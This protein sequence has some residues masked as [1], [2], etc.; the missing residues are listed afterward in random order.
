[1][2]IVITKKLL[3][4]VALLWAALCPPG[5]V[6]ADSKRVLVYYMPWFA[7]KPYSANWG[8]H[9][10][11][12]HFNPEILSVTGQR[13]IASW[14]YPLIGP[15]DSA[16]PAVLEYHVLLMKL[17]GIDGVV[18]DWYGSVNY[19]DYG[20]N[21]QA[22][23]K[24][25]QFARKAGLTCCICYEDQTIQHMIDGGYLAPGEAIRH[26]QQEVG[27]LQTNFFGDASYL[28]L[29]GRP[30]LLNFGPQH[31]L[32]SS[33]WEEIFSVLA[34]TNRP[35]FFT[36]DNR[37]E[38]AMGAFSWPPMWLSQAPGT[39]GI[40]SGAALK[41]YLAD[42]ERKS[43]GWPATISSAFPRFH[44]IYQR[45]GVRDF[46]GYLG[47]RHGDTLRETLSRGLTNS[48]AIVQ[49]VTWNDYGEGSMVE[50]T[51][52]YGYRDL[53]IIQDLRR[54]YLQPDFPCNTNDLAL[55][56]QFYQL[57]RQC[58]TNPAASAELDRIFG[59][60]ASGKLAVAKTRLEKVTAK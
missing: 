44:D 19:L 43:A 9:W 59:E 30:V 40:L 2:R 28:R 51:E 1:M 34:A 60:I 56:L 10:T 25:F 3:P 11:M 36:E 5:P 42:F 12:D 13:Q 38:P 8:W 47:D 17:S 55:A 24:L 14:Y 27:Y 16:D 50:P 46:W 33:N 53:G 45:A 22:T 23:V 54:Q 20:V 21:N 18:V 39:G 15:Y 41:S 31:F 26:A 7:A 6:H 29:Q 49:V 58:A 4:W 48:S 37:L 57:R 32:A 35:A 52:E